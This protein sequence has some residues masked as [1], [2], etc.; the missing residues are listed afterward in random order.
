MS[1][2]YYICTCF[3]IF[4]GLYTI[5]SNRKSKA[6]Q[7]FLSLTSSMAIWA[8]AY[9]IANSAPT[10]EASAFWRCMSVFGWGAFH[11]LLLHF[12]LI[13]TQAERRLNKRLMYAILYV[14]V[15][16]NIILFAPF[17]ILAEKQY[18]MVQ[19]AFGWKNA[20]AANAG[21]NWINIYYIIYTAI[22]VILLIYWWSK[23]KP[24]TPMKRQ[25][26]YFLLSILLP[27][28]GGSITDILPGILGLPQI[29]GLTPMFL[30]LPAIFL[31]AT[32]RKFGV[33]I[34]REQIEFRPSVSGLLPEEI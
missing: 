16:I 30:I 19:G 34:E 4:F 31:F 22:A 23:L 11:S 15:C 12:A 3:Y 32:L 28:L 25:V 17:G 5:A 14:P 2:I 13:L 10:A 6:N 20:L 24:H 26:T 29:P 21:Q 9:S 8:F 27:F 7:L 1:T 18:E 33:L